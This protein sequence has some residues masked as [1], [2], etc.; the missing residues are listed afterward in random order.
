MSRLSFEEFETYVTEHLGTY[1]TESEDVDVQV[2]DV[3]KN[4][5]TSY[6]AV[7]IRAD[8]NN[9][10]PSINLDDCYRDYES[11]GDVEAT[12]MRI[13]EFY[14]AHSN[15]IELNV[16]DIYNFD[17]MRDKII[18]RLVNYERNEEILKK[19]PYVMKMNLA[20]TFRWIADY[21]SCGIATAIVTNDQIRR[22][23]V[24]VDALYNIALN[25]TVRLFPIQMDTMENICL[26]AI[27]DIN[28][29]ER[30]R[31]ELRLSGLEQM[32]MMVLTN[33]QKINGATAILYPHCLYNISKELRCNFY[34]IPS[35][36]HEVILISKE[37]GVTTDYLTDIIENANDTVISDGDLL[38]YSLYEYDSDTDVL[39]VV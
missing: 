15:D 39:S 12:L 11:S 6:K 33:E 2:S 5:G 19:C 1:F 4:N 20:V 22:W 14:E 31:E 10:T 9:C 36:I 29:R 3:I 32:S 30:M 38:S 21:H 28:V 23:N 8:D 34:V 18:L 16:D 24:T 13:V 37:S 35:S 27:E 17:Y 25:N 26:S 7:Q